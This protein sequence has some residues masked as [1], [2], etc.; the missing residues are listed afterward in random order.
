MISKGSQKKEKWRNINAV[1]VDND[2]LTAPDWNG[3]RLR[4]IQE[5]KVFIANNVQNHTLDLTIL[6]LMWPVLIA[7]NKSCNQLILI[8]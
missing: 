6:K 1:H 7:C 4:N 8:K 5:L 3:T 2:L